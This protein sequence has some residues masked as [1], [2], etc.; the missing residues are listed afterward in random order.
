MIVH[1]AVVKRVGD[2]LFFSLRTLPDFSMI[3]GMLF[4]TPSAWLPRSGMP[5]HQNVPCGASHLGMCFKD[6]D[7]AR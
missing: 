7:C 2:G 5:G 6:E 1:D 3:P 4:R